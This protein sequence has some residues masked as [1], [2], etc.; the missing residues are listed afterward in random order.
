MTASYSSN[1]TKSP[2]SWRQTK[3]KYFLNKTKKKSFGFGNQG[4]VKRYSNDKNKNPLKINLAKT[5]F[6]S[7][8]VLFIFSYAGFLWLTHDLPDPNRLIERQIAQS[9]KIYDRTGQTV[10]YEI[11]GDQKR[12]M[13]SL[14]DVPDNL[15][16][17]TI[18]IEDK[19][20]Y[21]HGGFSLWAIFRTLVTDIVLAKWLAAQP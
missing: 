12:T 10:L 19:D 11:H 6:I 14:K 8:L 9:T 2:Q 15:K 18:A 3:K 13:I 20:F 7:L 4:G 21:K 1:H 5:I 16:N 17:A